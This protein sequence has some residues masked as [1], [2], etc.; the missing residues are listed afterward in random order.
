M[1][2]LMNVA[3]VILIT[4]SIAMSSG[5]PSVFAATTNQV[6]IGIILPLSGSSAMTGSFLRHAIELI[7]N[8]VNAT[9][10]IKSLKGAKIVPVWADSVGKPENGTS[11]AERLILK[12]KVCAILGSYSSAVCVTSAAVAERYKTPFVVVIGIKDS[13]T[14]GDYKFVFRPTGNMTMESRSCVDYLMDAAKGAGDTVKSTALI[15]ENSDYGSGMAQVWKKVLADYGVKVVCDESYQT[16]ILDFKPIILKAK[17]ANPDATLVV[18]YISDSILFTNAIRELDFHPK[19]IV[20]SGG[21]FIDPS[22][23]KNVGNKSNYIS[24]F[25][26]WSPSVLSIQSKLAREIYEDYT[27]TY[28]EELTGDACK[29]MVSAAVLLDAIERA[30]STNKEKIRVA[31]TK[32]NITEGPAMMIPVER[33]AFDKNGQNPYCKPAFAQM[34]NQEYIMTWPS[35]IKA[36]GAKIVWPMPE[37]Y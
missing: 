11:E 16:G 20:C 27:K 33:V 22:Y 12:E 21:G 32:T 26:G 9:G 35:Y 2:R 19:Q 37:K 10:G 1:K 5:F 24:T 4:V 18:G 13:L 15:Y 28:K 17:A 6:K 3:L 36:S 23:F 31:L 14:N 7:I 8:R 29:A 25:M 30:A 34:V